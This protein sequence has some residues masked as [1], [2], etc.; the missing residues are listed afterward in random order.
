VSVIADS[1]TRLGGRD[2]TAPVIL[3]SW[4]LQLCMITFSLCLLRTASSRESLLCLFFLVPRR[5]ECPE[6]SGTIQMSSAWSVN[7]RNRLL[8]H[9][10]S[11]AFP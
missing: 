2:G 8:L 4:A 7:L 1:G 10:V 3:V 9:I 5:S 11:N 6:S